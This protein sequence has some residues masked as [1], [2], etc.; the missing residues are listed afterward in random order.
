MKKTRLRHAAVILLT[1]I[2][3]SFFQ[4]AGAQSGAL[5]VLDSATL[6]TQLEYIHSNTRVYDNFR[7]IREDIFLK[8]KRNVL[9]TLI[10]EKLQVAQLNS[11]L[12]ERNF[13]IE[14]L[15]TD[16][17]RTKNELDESIRN[18]NSL[19]IFGISMNKAVYNS[20]MWFIVLGLAA[21]AVIMLVLFRRSHI[22]TSQTKN[23]LKTTLEEFDQYRKNSRE[24]Y[25]KM[26]VSHH[27]EIMKL[28]NS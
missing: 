16:L 25:E 4:I 21:L 9:D 28:K 10:A 6:E 17:G 12:T 1:A 23:E 18:K 7:A 13:E 27:H 3:S 5:V 11:R 20:V 8:L 24:K 2:F 14:R 22:V 19:S 15:N 26:V